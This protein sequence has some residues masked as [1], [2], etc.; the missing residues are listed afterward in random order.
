[1]VTNTGEADGLRP[2]RFL[3]QPRRVQVEADSQGQPCRVVLRGRWQ[4]VER[5]RDVWRID[6][7]WWREQPIHRIYYEIILNEG[8]VTTLFHDVPNGERTSS[9]WP[10]GGWPHGEWPNGGWPDGEWPDGEWY[11]QRG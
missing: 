5:V 10:N 4:P 11:E 1:M 8:A 2:L 7:E 3:N 6:D 9:E